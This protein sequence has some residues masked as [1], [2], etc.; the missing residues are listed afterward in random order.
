MHGRSR[1]VRWRSLLG[2]LSETVRSISGYAVRTHVL[3]LWSLSW[4]V[5]GKMTAPSM[6]ELP[7]F[8]SY[9]VPGQLLHSLLW[10]HL[11][12][13]PVAA[14][15]RRAYS[16]GWVMAL[17]SWPEMCIEIVRLSPPIPA[18]AWWW[19]VCFAM[20]RG[21]GSA[22][23]EVESWV[24]PFSATQKRFG[25]V[26]FN[27]GCVLLLF[28]GPF[29]SFRQN[30]CVCVCVC[31]CVHMLLTALQ[32]GGVTWPQWERNMSVHRLKPRVW[33]RRQCTAYSQNTSWVWG[34]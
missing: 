10:G 6:Q 20:H 12:I 31:T 33:K 11:S 28:P 34:Y 8:I 15:D 1:T 27:L 26:F 4:D 14:W 21:F 17:V 29:C 16:T 23:S 30:S 7:G 9:P 25:L 19:G 13:F 32:R 22:F 2:V 3:R 24:L 18:M 5:H